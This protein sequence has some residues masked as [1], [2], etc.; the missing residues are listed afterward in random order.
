[1]RS[2]GGLPGADNLVASAP[3]VSALKAQASSGKLVG[4]ICASPAKVLLPI[5][6]LEGKKATA[7]P[8]FSDQLPDQ[9]ATSQRVVVDGNIVTSRGP[10]TALEWSLELAALLVG[11]EKADQVAKGLLVA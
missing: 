3:L 10:G 7:Y 1:M 5:G 4:A 9:S 11:K 2:Q 6:L 8:G